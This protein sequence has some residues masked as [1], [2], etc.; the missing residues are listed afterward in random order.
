MKSKNKCSNSPLKNVALVLV[1][2]EKEGP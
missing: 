1:M 2:N